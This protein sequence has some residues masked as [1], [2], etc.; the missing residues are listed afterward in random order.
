MM[1]MIYGSALTVFKVAGRGRIESKGDSKD[2]YG[3]ATGY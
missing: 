3:D 2:I 1:V